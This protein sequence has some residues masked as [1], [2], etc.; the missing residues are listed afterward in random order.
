MTELAT[1]SNGHNRRTMLKRGLVLAAGAFGVTAAG[2]EAQAATRTV[3]SVQTL[4]AKRISAR[5]P[6]ARK[7][8]GVMPNISADFS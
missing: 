3:P 1:T 7:S 8:V 4:V 5:C 6:P 2:K